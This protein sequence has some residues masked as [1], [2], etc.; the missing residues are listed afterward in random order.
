MKLDK[1][2]SIANSLIA[3]LAPSCDLIAVA[4]SVRRMK[5]EVKDLEIVVSPK[6]TVEP[7]LAIDLFGAAPDIPVDMPTQLLDALYTLR[8]T[9]ILEYDRRVKR[10]GAKY[11]RFIVNPGTYRS[12]ALD[13]FIADR[14]NFGNTLA[15]RTG[16]AEFS[17]ALVTQRRAGGLMPGY[18]P[19]KG[20][21]LWYDSDRVDC[22]TEE[23]FFSRLGIRWIEPQFRDANAVPELIRHAIGAVQ[24]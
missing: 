19:Q 8:E 21:Y 18:L 24:P 14:H 16:N 12:I 5:P 7:G 22:P 20:G 17:K 9:G 4:G 11:K 6:L 13:L 1:A 23:N 3:L 2:Q 15:L 10:D